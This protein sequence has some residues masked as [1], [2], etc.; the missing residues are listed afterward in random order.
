[1]LFGPDWRTCDCELKSFGKVFML[2]D[3]QQEFHGFFCHERAI[4]RRYQDLGR[5]AGEGC[6]HG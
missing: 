6:K 4:L 1:M 5:T 3:Y 2:V